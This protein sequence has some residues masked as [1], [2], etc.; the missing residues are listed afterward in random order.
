MAFVVAENLPVKSSYR[1]VSKGSQR[2]T[3]LN[4]LAKVSE[5]NLH[6]FKLFQ[7]AFELYH[8]K[9]KYSLLQKSSYEL[10]LAPPR[11]L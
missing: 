1:F 3:E 4:V 2:L 10:L 6:F 11:I 9:Q 7:G 5:S 8:L